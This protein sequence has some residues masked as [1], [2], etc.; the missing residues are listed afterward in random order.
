EWVSKLQADSALF[1]TISRK[2]E[3]VAEMQG[4]DGTSRLYAFTT[5]RRGLEA[6]LFLTGGIPSALAYSETKHMLLFNLSIL[7]AVASLALFGAWIYGD[8]YILNPISA[9]LSTVHRVGAGD[10]SARTGIANAPGELH[11]LVGAF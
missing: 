3:G 2:G 10:L 11:Q 1:A 6:N 8:R 7:C 5:L 4:L 9:L